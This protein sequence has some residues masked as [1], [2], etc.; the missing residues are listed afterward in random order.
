MVRVSENVRSVG[1]RDFGLGSGLEESAGFDLAIEPGEVASTVVL[2][3]VF[4]IRG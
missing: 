1:F 2:D 4:G 3:V